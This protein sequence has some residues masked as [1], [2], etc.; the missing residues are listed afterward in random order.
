MTVMFDKIPR[1]AVYCH[2]VLCVLRIIADQSEVFDDIFW[3]LF[4]MVML[5]SP[6][7]GLHI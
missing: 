2:V 3:M 5:G 4:I 1:D 7:F 6:Q